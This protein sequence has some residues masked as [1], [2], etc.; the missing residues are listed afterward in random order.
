MTDVE[1]RRLDFSYGRTLQEN[2]GVVAAPKGVHAQV[3]KAV[4]EVL[5]K[6][7]KGAL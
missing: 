6:K 7:K 4:Q 1:G 3:I 2:K 5:G